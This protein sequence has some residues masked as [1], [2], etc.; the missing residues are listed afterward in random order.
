MVLWVFSMY[1]IVYLSGCQAVS[2]PLNWEKFACAATLISFSVKPDFKFWSTFLSKILVF[3]T[4]HE[5]VDSFLTSSRVTQTLKKLN[6]EVIQK[7]FCLYHCYIS[8]FFKFSNLL[9][10]RNLKFSNNHYICFRKFSNMVL[11]V[12]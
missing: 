7:L 11:S 6:L 8:C 5:I 1:T 4:R 3:E 12:L 9:W 2:W 10:N